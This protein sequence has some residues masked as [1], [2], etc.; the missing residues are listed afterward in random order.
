MKTINQWNL[1][2]KTAQIFVLSQ[3]QQ[4]VILESVLRC[5]KT[6]EREHACNFSAETSS[7]SSQND[8]NRVPRDR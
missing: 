2:N 5:A 8:R 4:S 7:Q 6:L 1:N 3:F